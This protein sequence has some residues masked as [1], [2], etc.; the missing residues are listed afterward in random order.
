VHDDDDDAD[1]CQFVFSI[2]HYT[3]VLRVAVRCEEESLQCWSEEAGDE[4]CIANTV[5]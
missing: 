5:G 3:T 1:D 4:R 2:V